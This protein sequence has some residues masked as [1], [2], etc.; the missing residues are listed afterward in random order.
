MFPFTFQWK[1]VQLIRGF[2]E[3]HNG[4]GVSSSVYGHVSTEPTPIRFT[5]HHILEGIS[6]PGRKSK[7]CRWC[8]VCFKKKEKGIPLL[9]P[10]L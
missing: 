4:S 7:P 6:I 1:R 8:V 2:M 3:K 5:E 9:M 10:Q